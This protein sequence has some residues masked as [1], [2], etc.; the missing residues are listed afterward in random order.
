MGLV[1]AIELLARNLEK[2]VELVVD[3]DADKLEFEPDWLVSINVYRIVQETLTNIARHSKATEVH[4]Q[5]RRL[6]EQ[7]VVTV[8]DNGLGLAVKDKQKES[9]GIIGM[10]ERARL[11]QGSFSID[12]DVNG[13]TLITV[14]VPYQVEKIQCVSC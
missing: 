8:R 11:V 4:L 9:L 2:Q 10:A 14:K 12:S 1:A 6:D 7:L 5:L 13:G 3:V